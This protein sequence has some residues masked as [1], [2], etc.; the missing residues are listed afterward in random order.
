MAFP[1]TSVLDPFNRADGAIGSNWLAGFGD[2]LPAINSNTA[3]GAASGWYGAVWAPSGSV[4]SFGPDCEAYY[5]VSVADASSAQ[6]VGIVARGSGLTTGSYN[7]Y[8][9]RI[10][11]VTLVPEIIKFASGT[12]TVLNAAA[13]ITLAAGDKVGISC[14]SNVI[15]LWYAP[16]GVWPGAATLTATD[17]TYTGAGGVATS[18]NQTAANSNGMDDFGGGTIISGTLFTKTGIGLIGP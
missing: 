14:I 12:P 17:S 7:G 4:A 18:W 11:S 3:K 13:A 8:M 6:P 9:V 1:T 5:T 15:T 16:A 10:H 2:S